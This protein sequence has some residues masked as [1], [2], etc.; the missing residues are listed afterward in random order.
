MLP[1]PNV[2]PFAL[3][4]IGKRPPIVGRRADFGVDFK[5][6]RKR[7]D[8]ASQLHVKRL[9]KS[10]AYFMDGLTGQLS[11]IQTAG[12]HDSRN[13]TRSCYGNM[14]GGGRGIRTPEPLSGL[15]V[16]KTAGFNRSPIPPHLFIIT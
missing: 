1:A 7:E 5:E 9:G 15:T 11:L 2:C 13:P 14:S 12:C 10:F 16:F 6:S 4:L 3:A 8:I